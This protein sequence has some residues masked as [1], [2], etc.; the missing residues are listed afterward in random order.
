MKYDLK[1]IHTYKMHILLP[2]CKMMEQQW[3][4]CVTCG[5]KKVYL[6]IC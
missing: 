3:N 4:K 1:T 6:Y 5:N 2:T